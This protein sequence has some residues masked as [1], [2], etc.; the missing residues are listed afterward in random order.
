MLDRGGVPEEVALQ[1]E[2]EIQEDVAE[3]EKREA[4]EQSPKTTKELIDAT[5]NAVDALV[6]I[7]ARNDAA[8][9]QLTALQ[10]RFLFYL[11]GEEGEPTLF[12]IALIKQE[13]DRSVD[14][15][16]AV[17]TILKIIVSEVNPVL[18]KLHRAIIEHNQATQAGQPANIILGEEAG[19]LEALLTGSYENQKTTTLFGY[20]EGL[21]ASEEFVPSEFVVI[22]PLSQTQDNIDY[23]TM[24]QAAHEVVTQ[25]KQKNYAEL[26]AGR[27]ELVLYEL[28]DIFVEFG[29]TDLDEVE[30]D[31]DGSKNKPESKYK[32]FMRFLETYA[33]AFVDDFTPAVRRLSAFNR[34]DLGFSGEEVTEIL[35]VAEEIKQKKPL[36]YA[37]MIGIAPGKKDA[38]V[39]RS[40]LFGNAF[41][42]FLDRSLR[43]RAKPKNR[44]EERGFALTRDYLS[45]LKRKNAKQ[46]ELT[47]VNDEQLAQMQES[48]RD[49]IG[50][51]EEEQNPV[52]LVMLVHK[53]TSANAARTMRDFLD[54]VSERREQEDLQTEEE[55]REE[56]ERREKEREQEEQR[57]RVKLLRGLAEKAATQ[58]ESI[59]IGRSIARIQA[60]SGEVIAITSD[61][62]D[63][64]FVQS[65]DYRESSKKGTAEEFSG[66]YLEDM[67]PFVP[68][69]KLLESLQK[70]L[71]YFAEPHYT[72]IYIAG[73]RRLI[74]EG[75]GHL[76][77]DLALQNPQ[78]VESR[79]W[80]RAMP[81]DLQKRLKNILLEQAVL[82]VRNGQLEIADQVM[83]IYKNIISHSG[84]GLSDYFIALAEQGFLQQALER[85]KQMDS[86]REL[87]V[88]VRQA[89]LPFVLESRQWKQARIVI[90]QGMSYEQ[91]EMFIDLLIAKKRAYGDCETDLKRYKRQFG[92]EL[93]KYQLEQI[94]LS[95][96]FGKEGKEAEVI[97]K[98]IEDLLSREQIYPRDL[99]SLAR[100]CEIHYGLVGSLPENYQKIFLALVEKLST[101]ARGSVYCKQSLQE[102]IKIFTR[103]KE[104]KFAL[105][106]VRE[107][108]VIVE[109]EVLS[110]VIDEENAT[111]FIE[112]CIKTDQLVVAKKEYL[113]LHSK[114]EKKKACKLFLDHALEAKD[115][116]S[117]EYWLE[118]FERHEEKE[119]F[120]TVRLQAEELLFDLYLE[121]NSGSAT[122]LD[123]LEY[124]LGRLAPE[125]QKERR[126]AFVTHLAR[127]MHSPEKSFYQDFLMKILQACELS[128]LNE[129]CFIVYE[130]YEEE[131]WD[132]TNF[133][134]EIIDQIEEQSPRG[135]GKRIEGSDIHRAALS[136]QIIVD[137]ATS[138]TGDV[139]KAMSML[140]DLKERTKKT[141]GVAAELE[142]SEY[143]TYVYAATGDL[144]KAV[145]F[146]EKQMPKPKEGWG[147][148]GITNKEHIKIAK[149]W[150]D[151]VRVRVAR[152]VAERET[153]GVVT[154]LLQMPESKE[155]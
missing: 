138:Q 153:T 3:R 65:Y 28:A 59:E 80:E 147:G 58:K 123:K 7:L 42:I 103:L 81:Y 15:I 84:D 91:M 11:Q 86:E 2:R 5:E 6:S 37:R 78:K 19:L 16:E 54:G 31:K 115:V 124:Y 1:V 133:A 87:D 135:I 14:E 136:A 146:I 61:T 60:R 110:F 132:T 96:E 63:I 44:D 139:G 22:N 25:E 56:Q 79:M 46:I 95:K 43:S 116:S 93:Y 154:S 17:H 36:F 62:R 114:K 32:K 13:D 111:C 131:G 39:E 66:L 101:K 141:Y 82:H 10:E 74:D 73:V 77:A 98:Q 100:A 35:A 106:I 38:R 113:K 102:A 149:A 97:V 71:N 140:L 107:A 68:K 21:S 121:M 40:D 8:L 76:C 18:Y 122:I 69:E 50:L 94:R 20:L 92:K 34:K 72:A 126:S 88:Q 137:K 29:A 53:L 151:R 12:A 33:D 51:E 144:E 143:V 120:E 127:L 9:E 55:K 145:A 128:E 49:E 75:M 129:L 52:L 83:G 105:R 112:E 148:S 90:G 130:R 152:I 27:T 85:F 24:H 23:W 125:R 48:L 142:V 57:K 26:I 134:N 47:L 119:V 155:I 45:G 99:A 89:F 30:E 64:F 117:I 150:A 67:L 108:S 70:T 41:H 118:E 104:V 109:D 4:T